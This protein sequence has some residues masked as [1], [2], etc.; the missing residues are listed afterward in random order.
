[1]SRTEKT[2]KM[3]LAALMMCMIVVL[4][5]FIKIPIPMTQGYVHLGDAMI[6]MAVMLLGWKYGAVAAGVGSAMADIFCGAA[7][8]APWTLVVKFVMALIM[9]LILDK[10]GENIGLP[11]QITAMI[12]GGLFMVLGY[13]VAEGVMYGNWIAA[14]IGIPWNIGQ[15]AVGMVIATVISASL[16]RTSANRIFTYKLAKHA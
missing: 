11:R 12:C 8:W 2:N 9:G 16:C 1:M 5:M 13:Y 7:M 3:V 15:F 14:T 6:F 10:G 4:T